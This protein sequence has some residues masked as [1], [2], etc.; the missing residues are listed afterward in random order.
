MHDGLP[1]EGFD[2]GARQ[3]GGPARAK[4]T[5]RSALLG[6]KRT[7][8]LSV[9]MECFE[10]FVAVAD[11]GSIVDAAGFLSVEERTVRIRRDSLGRFCNVAL[12]QRRPQI[13][14]SPDGLRLVHIARAICEL[15]RDFRAP[16]SIEQ[17]RN[18]LAKEVRKVPN[19]SL[20]LIRKSDHDVVE[21][22]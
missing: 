10:T 21:V 18:L 6:P 7:D 22:D 16:E 13:I 12:F 20:R 1:G 15:A 17:L 8:R 19:K 9:G 4:P 5:Q 11:H 2:G 3:E 14:L